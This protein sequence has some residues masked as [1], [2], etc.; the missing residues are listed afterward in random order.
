MMILPI[1][2]GGPSLMPKTGS[3]IT[4]TSVTQT[5]AAVIG[6][7]KPKFLKKFAD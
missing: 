7:G 1:S 3:I 6:D 4:T 5:H 2:D